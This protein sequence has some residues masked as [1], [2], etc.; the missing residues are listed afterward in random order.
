[1]ATITAGKDTLDTR[2]VRQQG[3]RP[4]TVHSRTPVM[5][6][7]VKCYACLSANH[8]QTTC[9]LRRC[10]VCG[11]YSHIANQCMNPSGEH[12]HC[13]RAGGS[14]LGPG[15]TRHQRS[16][17]AA[18]T[19]PDEPA[20]HP[21]TTG[22]GS[23]GTGTAGAGATGTEVTGPESGPP[24]AADAGRWM[25][26]LGARPPLAAHASGGSHHGDEQADGLAHSGEP[27]LT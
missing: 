11:M 21:G 17:A 7:P 10:T 2:H 24:A 22:A 6:C 13:P 20:A 27:S 25:V 19:G 1:M 14:Q 5:V 12:R 4:G 16:S 18:D 3:A 15:R 23:T 26:M 8:T 9:P